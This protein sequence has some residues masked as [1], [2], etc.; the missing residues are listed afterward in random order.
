MWDLDVQNFQEESGIAEHY[1][2]IKN[3]LQDKG[4]EAT[5]QKEDKIISISNIYYIIL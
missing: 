1:F 5:K 4:W 2:D 3:F